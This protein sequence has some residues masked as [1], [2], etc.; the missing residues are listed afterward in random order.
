MYCDDAWLFATM[1]RL[2]EIPGKLDGAL[3]D[4]NLVAQVVT[5]HHH[6]LRHCSMT[7][8]HSGCYAATH[9]APPTCTSSLSLSGDLAKEVLRRQARLRQETLPD[10]GFI[11]E[12][13]E[14]P[15][16]GGVVQLLR[17]AQPHGLETTCMHPSKSA[18]KKTKRVVLATNRS[19]DRPESV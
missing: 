18:K 19:N 5:D 16:L 14:G 4:D 3:I 17:H 12:P 9:L 10:F 8:L 2:L 15:R 13:Q 11:Q 7:L 1:A 6:A